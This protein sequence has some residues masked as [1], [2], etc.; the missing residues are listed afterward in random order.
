MI[1]VGYLSEVNSKYVRIKLYESNTQDIIF[2]NGE[3]YEMPKINQYVKIR[4]LDI[5]IV[6]QIE[7]EEIQLIQENNK[8]LIRKKIDKKM[9]E[10]ILTAKIIGYFSE[11]SFNIGPKYSPIVFNE[12]L[13]LNETELRKIIN[14]DKS[15]DDN[16][17]SIGRSIINDSKLEIP[18]NGFLNSHIA[19]FG[20]TGSGKSNTLTKLYTELFE[21]YNVSNSRFIFIDFNGEYTSPDVL[22][23]EKKII[24]LST[25]IAVSEKLP[26]DEKLFFDYEIMSLLYHATE[27]TQKP[28]LNQVLTAWKNNSNPPSLENYFI[29]VL[30][31]VF[32]KNEDLEAEVHTVI[33][34]ILDV[35]SDSI[36][37]NYEISNN[38]LYHNKGKYF[39]LSN[40]S[41][42]NYKY[43]LSVMQGHYTYFR[44]NLLK[45]NNTEFDINNINFDSINKFDELL[46]RCELRLLSNLVNKNNRYEFI[47]PL[48]NKIA[49]TN[50][51]LKKVLKYEQVS[52]EDENTTIYSLKNCNQEMKKVIPLLLAKKEYSNCK[53]NE[54]KHTTHFI[55]DEAHNILSSTSRRE[56]ETWKDYRLE[57]FE[58]IIK[59]GRKFGFFITLSSQRPSD[60]SNTIVSQIHN[61]LIHKLINENDLYL[62]KNVITT[63]SK[64]EYDF[65]P[66]MGQ[67]MCVA[68]GTRFKIPQIIQVDNLIEGKRPDSDDIELSWGKKK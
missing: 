27:K 60:I 3:K 59:E 4:Y 6:A 66:Q 23:Q 33:E 46:L 62:V 44:T 17:I 22:T 10:R 51:N 34:R 12:V 43:K 30:K 20:N 8:D 24:K 37:E 1:K 16:S 28:F 5:D 57:T 58:E 38:V 41:K 68:S 19:I 39:Y 55:I 25:N 31:M 7:S 40:T 32:S 67:G 9:F 11:N 45:K 64:K 47:N 15:S 56:G 52:S 14:I 18:I 35:I 13:L 2:L 65:I 26:I 50:I 48:I 54:K 53:N 42:E 63:L 49:S 29:N 21:N 36:N 61:F